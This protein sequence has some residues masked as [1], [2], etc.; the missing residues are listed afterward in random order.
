MGPLDLTTYFSIY[1]LRSACS[2]VIIQIESITH[3]N[4]TLA[5]HVHSK[6][7]L[8]TLPEWSW[9]KKA[10]LIIKG[11]GTSIT[12]GDRAAL[13]ESKDH[14]EEAR[15]SYLQELVK[16]SPKWVFPIWNSEF[17]GTADEGGRAKSSLSRYSRD[18]CPRWRIKGDQLLRELPNLTLGCCDLATSKKKIN[19]KYCLK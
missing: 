15:V 1:K 17:P 5:H 4:P 18:F 14:T 9:N 12:R 3:T 8:S 7:N 13:S 19:L 11:M 10:F 16:Y 2:T 6:C